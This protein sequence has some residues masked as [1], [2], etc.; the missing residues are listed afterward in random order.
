MQISL[1]N[2]IL[3]L[4]LILFLISNKYLISFFISPHED[5]FFKILRL[6]EEDFLHYAFLVEKLSNFSLKTDWSGLFEVEGTIGFPIFSLIWHAIFF[7][8]FNYNGFLIV[9][10]IFY[11][12]NFFLL[13][14]ILNEI[15]KDKLV[16]F[17][18]LVILYTFLEFLKITY[19]FTNIN[20]LQI[21]KLPINEF[22]GNRF[23]RPLITSTY[24][25][26]I[27]YLLLKI[28]KT[29]N[30]FHSNK[31]ILGVSI[32]FFLLINS[33]FYLFI[34]LTILFIFYFFK[35]HYFNNSISIKINIRIIL[36]YIFFITLGF[37]VFFLQSFFSEPDY[38]IR[39]GVY[40]IDFEDKLL[41]IKI[42]FKKLL[43]KEFLVLAFMSSIFFLINKSYEFYNKKLNI[44][45]YLFISTIISPFIFV[46]LTNKIISLY[47]FWTAIKFSGFLY[48]IIL[49]TSYVSSKITIFYKKFLITIC[50]F[51]MLFLNIIFNII[52]EK[53]INSQIIL[54]QI[55]LKNFLKNN[56]KYL[57]KNLILFSN[58]HV[59]NHLWIKLENKYFINTSAFVSSLNDNQLE[60]IMM[61]FFKLYN[62]SLRSFSYSLDINEKSLYDRN[63][64]ATNF[65][66]KYSVN[67]LRHYKP[68]DDEYSS[69]LINR[70]KNVSPLIQWYTFFPNSEKKRLINKY[71]YIKLNKEILPDILILKY[72]NSHLDQKII[73]EHYSQVFSNLNFQVFIKKIL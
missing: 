14:F 38:D 19:L 70:I 66:Y 54:D 72:P 33:F 16:A 68:I 3:L 39:I 8:M 30:F 69:F 61:N 21:L 25:F 32:V 58:D 48:L 34:P 42:F 55:E 43:Q 4:I 52:N 5:F 13:F 71:E 57:K 60:N 56:N 17:L 49:F 29:K 51:L 35:L 65:N 6:G 36:I 28:I 9:E 24:F 67:L 41:L 50:L 45:F 18:I 15:F 53:K 31:Y 37:F 44:F 47:H 20:F 40:F 22:I 26:L 46:I 11:S 10:L 63:N 59:V 27:I 23:P 73:L 2:K 1:K 12:L 7:K 64:L 62:I